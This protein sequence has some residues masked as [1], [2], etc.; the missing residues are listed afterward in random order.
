MFHNILSVSDYL[1]L[2]SDA[3][4]QTN[5]DTQTLTV[6]ERRKFKATVNEGC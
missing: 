4:T 1:L 5:A 3:D 2:V 6:T